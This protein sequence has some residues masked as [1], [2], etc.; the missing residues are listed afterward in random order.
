MKRLLPAR[1]GL[2]IL[3]LC[4]F[5]PS[6]H[7]A[8]P[9]TLVAPPDPERYGVAVSATKTAKDLIEV[10]N[11]AQ[12]VSGR[13]LQLRG[14]R[15][16]ADALEDVVG[17]DTGDGSDNGVRFPN[18]GMWGLKESDALLFMLD[19]VPLGGDW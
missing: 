14:S 4:A 17:I 12:V 3:L 10:P 1:A 19:G 2:L 8:A 7:A 18:V 5:V 16:L 6:A 11:A 15:T 13:D 9:D